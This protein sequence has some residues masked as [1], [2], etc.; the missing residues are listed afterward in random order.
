[1]IRDAISKKQNLGHLTTLF[2]GEGGFL[3]L[4]AMKNA[5]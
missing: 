1:V 4:L 3:I 5:E 2:S